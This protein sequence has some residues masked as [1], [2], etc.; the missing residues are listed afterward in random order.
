LNGNNQDAL[1]SINI[2]IKKSDINDWQ[3]YAF[4][5]NVYEDLREYKQA[6]TDYEQAIKFNANEIQVY[7][8]YHQIGFCY[9]SLGNNQKAFEFYTQAIDLKKQHPNSLQNKDLEG[10]DGGVMLGLSFKKMYNNRANALKNLGK[11]NEAVEDCKKSLSFD[12]NY[13]N[14]YLMLSQ[15]YS[16]AGQEQEATKYLQISA[17]L[18]NQSAISILR[19]LGI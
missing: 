11:L 8:L 17:Q 7:A 13:S 3:H 5:G 16:K 10:M 12:K 14:P 9:L 18:G 6:I 19:Q 15:I 2:V 4:R 1:A